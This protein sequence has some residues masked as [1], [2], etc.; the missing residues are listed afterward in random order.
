[1]SLH[2]IASSSQSS[3]N[4]RSSWDSGIG[5]KDSLNRCPSGPISFRDA[6]TTGLTQSGDYPPLQHRDDIDSHFGSRGF[7]S[8]PPEHS[9]SASSFPSTPPLIQQFE[10]KHSSCSPAQQRRKVVGH[11]SLNQSPT[12][13]KQHRSLSTT[14]SPKGPLDRRSLPST[15]SVTRGGSDIQQTYAN[16]VRG[17]KHQVLDLQ[18]ELIRAFAHQ[19]PYSAPQT[20]YEEQSDPETFEGEFFED[21]SH[22]HWFSLSPEDQKRSSLAISPQIYAGPPPSQQ[23]QR[24]PQRVSG[25]GGS[26]SGSYTKSFSNPEQEKIARSRGPSSATSPSRRS[27]CGSQGP[28]KRPSS[29]TT[30]VSPLAPPSSPNV[31]STASPPFFSLKIENP[32]HPNLNQQSQSN[33]ETSQIK[34]ALPSPVTQQ[35]S[36]YPPQHLQQI[37]GGGGGA[38][39]PWS[40]IDFRYCTDEV[41]PGL[42]HSYSTQP[43]NPNGRE[44]ETQQQRRAVEEGD[45]PSCEPV[46]FRDRHTIR[47]GLTSHIRPTQQAPPVV[48]IPP[49]PDPPP[50]YLMVAPDTQKEEE[51]SLS[52]R[53]L[54]DQLSVEVI[55]FPPFSPPHND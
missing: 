14:P 50:P 32:H 21:S 13:L 1:M 11:L 4:I 35:P 34:E 26:G 53:I 17:G 19:S 42:V 37:P 10:Y 15:P 22:S 44:P 33:E 30:I 55:S 52:F 5:K 41:L 51:I 54:R 3:E 46:P 18:Q 40:Q 31:P 45:Q 48:R 49:P 36:S 24:S 27:R 9:N 38:Q 23:Q 16:R 43:V 7:S 47:Q 12:S 20:S 39:Q 6:A 29:F 8:T 28:S 25:S 2:P